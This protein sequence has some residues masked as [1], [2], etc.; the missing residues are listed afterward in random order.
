M[1]PDRMHLHHRM[2]RIGHSVQSAVLILWAWAALISF[3]SVMT[4][5]VRVRYVL[6]GA[7]IAAV[8]LTAATLAPYYKQKRRE[9]GSNSPDKA[10]DTAADG[11]LGHGGGRQL[12]R[13]GRGDRGHAVYGLHGRPD[14][15][16]GNGRHA[17]IG[18]IARTVA[19][20]S[21]PAAGTRRYSYYGSDR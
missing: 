10:G 21:V 11:K 20:E 5:F 2:L 19:D 9:G 18:D 3:S 7:G 15:N 17:G 16:S 4:I 13:A 6:I 1:H 8:L 14:N 12:R